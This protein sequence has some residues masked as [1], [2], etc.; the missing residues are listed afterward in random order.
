MM[1]LLTLLALFLFINEQGWVGVGNYG[2]LQ[3]LRF[4]LLNL[5]GQLLQFLPVAALIGHPAG[6]GRPWPATAN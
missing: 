4:V 3:A 2:S 1:V 5:P 6:H